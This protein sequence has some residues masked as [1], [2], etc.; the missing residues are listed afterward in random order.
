MSK[1]YPKIRIW[2]MVFYMPFFG[3][4]RIWISGATPG[5]A[6]GVPRGVPGGGVPPPKCHPNPP[7]W[8][9]HGQN[10]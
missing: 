8:S 7:I 2:G 10:H 3:D 4:R 9:A 6:M 1:I 5:A